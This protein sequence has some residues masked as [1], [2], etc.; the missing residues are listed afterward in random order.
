MEPVY[1]PREMALREPDKPAL[2]M[3]DQGAMITYGE[4]VRRCT[5]C[6]ER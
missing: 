2:I 1:H 6:D 5:Q 3:V 4:L